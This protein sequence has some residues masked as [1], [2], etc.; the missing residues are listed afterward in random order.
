MA[1]ESVRPGTMGAAW[2]RLAAA[3]A[4]FAAYACGW[5]V[6]TLLGG[7]PAALVLERLAR[8]LP[9]GSGDLAQAGGVLAL[10][11]LV[12]GM[13]PLGWAASA[14]LGVALAWGAAVEPFL[15]GA[16]LCRLA[17]GC[18]AGCTTRHG[19]RARGARHFLR[20]LVLQVASW[21]WLAAVAVALAF[22]VGARAAFLL[23]AVWLVSSV[24]QDAAAAA[25]VTAPAVR[26]GLANWAR[27]LRRRP[28]ATIGGGLLLRSGAQVPL[29]LLG[30]LIAAGPA[31]SPLRPLLLF[32]LPVAALFGRAVWWALATELVSRSAGASSPRFPGEFRPVELDKA[33]AVG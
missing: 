25:L 2:R 23:P 27:T 28:I 6:A 4:G 13:R 33:R 24:L 8:N 15:R 20:M 10:E 29:A 30:V 5:L 19:T 22:G 9:G 32:G 7:L 21:A 31:G 18:G 26:A 17:A 14:A 16:L 11:A 12:T 1:A 3:R